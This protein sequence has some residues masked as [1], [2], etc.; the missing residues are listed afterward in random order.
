[1]AVEL[2]VIPSTGI[3]LPFVSYGGTAQI[4]LLLA[5]GL[6][7]AVSRSGTRPAAPKKDQRK[8]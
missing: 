3:T 7:M 4:F 8:R 2:Q 1:M 6:I 5:Y